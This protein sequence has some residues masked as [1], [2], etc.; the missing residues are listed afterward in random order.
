VVYIKASAV[1]PREGPYEIE[2]VI[3]KVKFRLCDISTKMTAKD[4]K[5][6]GAD[7]LET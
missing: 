3:S 6:F 2:R 1:G 7:E 4:G 5:E